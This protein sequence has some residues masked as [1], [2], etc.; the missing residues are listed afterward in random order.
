M[1]GA[2]QESFEN[3]L[4]SLKAAG[5]A[6]TNEPELRERLAQARR[7]RYAF[8]TLAANGGSIGICFSEKDTG[9]DKASVCNTFASYRFPAEFDSVFVSRLQAE[10]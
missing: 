9:T 10:Y 5:V 1:G 2:Y 8:M 7:W 4:K 6:I 3:F